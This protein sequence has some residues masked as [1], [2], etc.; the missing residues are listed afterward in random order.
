LKSWVQ[1]LEPPKRKEGWC[2]SLK[3]N[4]T[5]SRSTAVSTFNDLQS[6]F[7]IF[8][9]NKSHSWVI[10]NPCYPLTCFFRVSIKLS[11]HSI[12]VYLCTS[13]LLWAPGGQQPRPGKLMFSVHV[14]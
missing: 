5:R 13:E 12:P 8:Q 7:F 6:L 3:K 14:Y 11:V 2:F 9:P 10:Q 4:H 1:T